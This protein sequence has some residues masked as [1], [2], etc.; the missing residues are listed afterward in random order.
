MISGL[1]RNCFFCKSLRTYFLFKLAETFEQDSHSILTG[2]GYRNPI[3]LGKV[4]ELVWSY[5]A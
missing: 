4:M 3:S 5:G 2:P 1:L